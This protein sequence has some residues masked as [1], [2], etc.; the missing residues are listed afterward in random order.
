MVARHYKELF[1]W[2]LAEELKLEVYGMIRSSKAA[3]ADFAYRRQV[4]RAVRSVPANLAEGFRRCSPG[5]FMRFLDYSMGSLGETETHLLDGVDLGYFSADRCQKAWRLA[6]RC[7]KACNGL[8]QSQRRYLDQLAK[9][10][11]SSNQ[12]RSRIRRQ[13]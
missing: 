8:K 3:W 4:L 10:G 7:G 9:T 12:R 6:R 1:A 13:T 2:Q 5:D 11:R